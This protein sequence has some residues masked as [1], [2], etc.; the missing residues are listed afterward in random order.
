M[1]GSQKLNVGLKG[2][3]STAA[4]ICIVATSAIAQ[5]DAPAG[6][7]SEALRDWLKAEWYNP[8]F[9]DLGYNG[10]R[11]Q[12]FGYTDELDGSIYCIYTGFEQAS[13]YTTY[14]DP[15]NTEHIIP[16]SFFG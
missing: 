16:Q 11:S 9:S 4:A 13:E 12:M 1:L 2:V 7:N 8:Y 14:L 6:L 15:I 10:A 3:F 5:P